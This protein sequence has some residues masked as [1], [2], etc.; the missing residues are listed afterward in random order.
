MDVR[1]S[2]CGVDVEGRG[3]TLVAAGRLCS[4]C[5]ERLTVRFY[6]MLGVDILT[7]DFDAIEKLLDSFE[8]IGSGLFLPDAARRRTA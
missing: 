2:R 1:C 8:R 3:W 7:P 5:R 6:E 4:D